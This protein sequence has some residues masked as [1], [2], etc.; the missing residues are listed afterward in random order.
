MSVTTA[1]GFGGFT[2][3]ADP[4]SALH[5]RGRSVGRVTVGRA[6]GPPS[7]RSV[8]FFGATA[9]TVFIRHESSAIRSFD[10]SATA[11]AAR[12]TNDSGCC[13]VNQGRL[14]SRRTRDFPHA[15]RLTCKRLMN[16][17]YF[18]VHKFNIDFFASTA[19]FSLV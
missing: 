12:K 16:I 19:V 17:E 15:R 10:A 18:F 2:L 1:P 4:S 14:R 11:G 5:L 3:V 7:R 8:V 9:Q 6:Q 13:R